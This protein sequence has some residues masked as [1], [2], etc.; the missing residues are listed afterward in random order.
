VVSASSTVDVVAP[1]VGD[2]AVALRIT[3]SGPGGVYQSLDLTAV[4]KGR[5]VV[6]VTTGR[7]GAVAFPDE[8]RV[9]LMTL[10]ASRLGG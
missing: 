2:E 7:V 6:S 1:I 3:L 9:R 10:M 8:E 4:R 5:A